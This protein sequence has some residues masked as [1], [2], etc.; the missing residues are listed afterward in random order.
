MIFISE[1]VN[2]LLIKDS[3]ILLLVIMEFYVDFSYLYH[4]FINI[5]YEL[6]ERDD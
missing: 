6:R 1:M 5:L 3:V 2:L 4:C